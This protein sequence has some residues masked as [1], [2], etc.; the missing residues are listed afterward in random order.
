MLLTQPTLC[1]FDSGYRF[2]G[3]FNVKTLIR[4]DNF[5]RI[6]MYPVDNQVQMEIIGI[7]VKSVDG[8]VVV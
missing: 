6:W 1:V 5:Q 3:C 7:G 8:L 2:M 4:L